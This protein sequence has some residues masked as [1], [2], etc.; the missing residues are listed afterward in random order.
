MWGLIST[1]FGTLRL[2]ISLSVVLLVADLFEPVPD[3]AIQR[4]LNGDM[5]HRDGRAC[6]MPMLLS[7]RNPNDIAGPDFLDRTSPALHPTYTGSDDQSLTSRWVCLAVRAPGSKV[8]LPQLTPGG[9]AASN[10]GSM[11][12]VPVKYSAGPFPEGREPHL[13]ISMINLHSC[14]SGPRLSH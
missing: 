5:R 12:T 8:T 6:A 3:F 10:R 11:R 4:L 14:A 2:L 13:L 1:S 7:R 9:L